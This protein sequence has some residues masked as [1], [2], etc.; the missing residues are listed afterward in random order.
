MFLRVSGLLL[1]YLLAGCQAVRPTQGAVSD[2]LVAFSSDEGVLRLNRAEAKADFFRLANQFEPQSNRAFCGPTSATIVLNA[3]FGRAPDLPRDASRLQALGVANGKGEADASLP[4]F[5]QENVFEH[6]PKTPAQ[7]LGAPM[8]VAGKSVRDG[9]FQLRQLAA[10]LTGNRV[11]THLVVAEAGQ[12]AEIR[13]EIIRN[14]KHAD[15]YV[16]VN[17]HRASVGQKGGGH[18]SPLA[19]YDAV[20]DS[21]LILDV[22]PAYEGW[23]WMPLAVLIRGMR[24]R[25]VIENRG[26]IAVKAL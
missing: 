26:Y 11:E 9:G 16:I 4:R 23:V 6:S 25:D 10:L 8:I 24:T 20:S 19:A 21:V 12:D 2:A 5:T 18:I 7:V 13:A 22:N 15:D 14:L 17:Y 1:V 3:L